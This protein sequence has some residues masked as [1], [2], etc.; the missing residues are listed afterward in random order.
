MMLMIF[1]DLLEAL[2]L[3]CGV[4]IQLNVT[5]MQN[6]NALKDFADQK[7]TWY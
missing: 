1:L 5:I 6:E 3:R 2:K 4:N 7:A